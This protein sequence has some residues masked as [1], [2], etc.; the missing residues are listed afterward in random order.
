MSDADAMCASPCHAASRS[1]VFVQVPKRSV[2][3]F[4][5]FDTVRG[6]DYA[7]EA[8]PRGCCFWACQPRRLRLNGRR[9]SVRGACGRPRR[10]FMPHCAARLQ[11]VP[12]PLPS[13]ILWENLAIR[14]SSRLCRRLV[15]LL[16]RGVPCLPRLVQRAL[17]GPPWKCD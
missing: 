4:V 14:K 2:N 9:L 15:T 17:H 16:V 13:A 12:A 3:A 5:T 6:R 7:L 11:V 8:Y 10:C 1:G